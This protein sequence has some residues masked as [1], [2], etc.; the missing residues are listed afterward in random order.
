LSTRET[1][2][3]LAEFQARFSAVLRTP[4]TRSTGTLL[5]DTAR[6]G[7]AMC[8]R[9]LPT[10]TQGAAERLA[11]YNRQYW[12]RLF[13]TLQ[14]QFPL[15]TQGL[16]PWQFNAHASHYLLTH[17]PHT[18]DLQDLGDRFEAFMHAEVSDAGVLQAVRMDAARHRVFY[19]PPQPAFHP[20]AADAETLMQRRLC[21]SL[22][23]EVVDERWAVYRNARGVGQLPLARGHARLLG[24]LREH[25][26][27]HAL[28]T[29]EAEC[30]AAERDAL[31]IEAQR[32]LAQSVELGFWTGFAE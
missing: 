2:L 15:T 18:A 9:V 27:E 19:A 21:P 8:Q 1:Q 32:W 16:G 30:P 12:F 4:L 13:N 14:G 6:Y 11:V 23:F 29:V 28:G 7:H 20:T 3:W 26:I 25:T 17:P 5:A 24:L 31:V 10:A 22:A